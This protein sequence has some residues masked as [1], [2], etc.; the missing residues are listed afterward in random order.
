M[1]VSDPSIVVDPAMSTPS[2]PRRRASAPKTL[3]RG[4]R[5]F[6]GA[7][8]LLF[9]GVALAV[10]G[11]IVIPP[12][13]A[14]DDST[15]VPEATAEPDPVKGLETFR[16]AG[17]AACHGQNGEGGIGPPLAG[18]T[19]EQVFRQVRSPI[20][21]VMPA[22]PVSKLSDEDVRNIA[23]WIDTLGEEML[24]AHEEEEQAGHGEPEL[25][26]T[27][28]AHLRLFLTSAEAD[29]LADALRHIDHLALHG[30]DAELLA[31]VDELRADLE[32]GRLH[33]AERKVLELLGPAA[34]GE[35]DAISAHLGMAIAANDRGEREDVT[36]H[37]ISAVDAAA[38]HDHQDVLQ[39]LLDDWVNNVDRHGVIDA[40][41]EA[42]NLEHPQH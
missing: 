16:Q 18:H 41:Y 37:L 19:E 5:L 20:G 31:Q 1:R 40:L 25:T 23:A 28:I 35:F 27:E 39:G 34:E 42:L 22:Y 29:N 7:F 11:L 33:D 30:G 24:M 12:S 32:A 21:D 26:P 9:V 4:Y 3:T 38:G 14:V 15:A 17:C 6:L 13:D 8:G 36:F 2:N 10:T